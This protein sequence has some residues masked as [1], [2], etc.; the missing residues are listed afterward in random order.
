[1]PSWIAPSSAPPN[2]VVKT[3]DY[4]PSA[5]Q[6]PLSSRPERSAASEGEGPAWGSITASE[7]RITDSQSTSTDA[8]TVNLTANQRLHQ[9]V[10]PLLSLRSV[11][12]GCQSG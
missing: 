12:S 8:S 2:E 3:H 7:F 6:K 5:P 10:F 1:M 9:H 11:R 4:K